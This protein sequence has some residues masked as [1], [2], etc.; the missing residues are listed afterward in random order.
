MIYPYNLKNL[1]DLKKI[2]EKEKLL[3]EKEFNEK[4][5]QKK[6]GEP[7]MTISIFMVI[8]EKLNLNDSNQLKNNFLDLIKFKNLNPLDINQNDEL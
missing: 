7:K 4:Y 2:S 5:I 6:F 3:I 8:G 1:V